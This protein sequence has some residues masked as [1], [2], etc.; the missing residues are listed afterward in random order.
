M[1]FEY[2]GNRRWEPSEDMVEVDT[3]RGVVELLDLLPARRCGVG[4]RK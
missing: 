4:T 1:G 2:V 3:D